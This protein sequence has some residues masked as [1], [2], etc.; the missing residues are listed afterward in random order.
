MG[1][2]VPYW[3]VRDREKGKHKTY[4]TRQDGRRKV[5]DGQLVP[6][7]V[8]S[9]GAIGPEGKAWLKAVARIAVRKGRDSASDSLP[10]FVQSLV[11]FFTAGSVLVAHGAS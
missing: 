7:A 9:Y 4:P 11:V 6:L 3:S 2:R 1:D 5:A 10:A 8:N